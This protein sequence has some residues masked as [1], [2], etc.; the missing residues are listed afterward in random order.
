MKMFNII[1]ADAKGNLK[2]RLQR[3]SDVSPYPGAISSNTLIVF[4]KKD[5]R[6]SDVEL[7]SLALITKVD[8]LSQYQA[9]PI[10]DVVYNINT[11]I[12]EGPRARK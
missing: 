6:L 5:L 7:K 1:T 11:R 2:E 4:V 12:E 3:A 9:M 10:D 8:R